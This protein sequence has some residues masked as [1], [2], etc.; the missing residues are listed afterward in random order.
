[1]MQR[2]LLVVRILRKKGG[3]GPFIVKSLKLKGGM[4]NKI[5]SEHYREYMTKMKRIMIIVFLCLTLCSI[6]RAIN[7]EQSA[8]DAPADFCK[9]GLAG[10]T[11]D[12][13]NLYVMAG[14]RIL[15]YDLAGASLLQTVSLPDLPAPPNGPPPAATDNGN[16]PP[17]PPPA[18]PHGIWA[19]AGSLYVL[20]G[21]SVYIYSVPDLTL[22]N[23]IQLPK[24][25][26]P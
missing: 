1:M 2:T 4:E 23:T 7:A 15:Q 8:G 16:F 25:A 5:Q 3:D 20:A 18:I 12:Q 17:P 21:P 13:K 14:G 19:G 24:P 22:A 26:L 11:S 10:I 6:D 9:L